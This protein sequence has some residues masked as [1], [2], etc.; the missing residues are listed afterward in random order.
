M[1]ITRKFQ[2][3]I[4]KEVREK[5]HLKI[6]Q[7]IVLVAKGGIIYLIPQRPLASYKGFIKIK[8]ATAVR[9]CEDR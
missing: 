2:V 8:A 5:L 4:P 1:T 7:K 9:E 6:G 3:S